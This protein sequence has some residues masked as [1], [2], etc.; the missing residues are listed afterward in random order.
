LE[1]FWGLMFHSKHAYNKPS[2]QDLFY[3]RF[4][5]KR[6]ISLCLER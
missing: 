2:Q 4:A 5:P 1:E 6:K 3:C